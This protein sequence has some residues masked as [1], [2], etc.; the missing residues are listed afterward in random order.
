VSGERESSLADPQGGPAATGEELILI[1]IELCY[2]FWNLQTF[3]KIPA[4]ASLQRRFIKEHENS[5]ISREKIKILFTQNLGP[6]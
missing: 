6:I 3:L 5:V 1:S 4:S 2:K